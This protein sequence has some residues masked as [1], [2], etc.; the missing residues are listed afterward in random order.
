MFDKNDLAHEL[1]VTARQ[2]TKLKNAFENNMS[3]DI[4][5]S[6]NQISKIMRSEGFL[7]SLLSKLADPL[8]K[9]A[10]PFAKNI[11]APLGITAATSAIDAGIQKKIHGS[12]TATLIISDEEMNDIM[13]IVQALEDSTIL[14]K[15]VTKTIK[16]GTK[17]QKGRILSMLYATLGAS[18]SGNLLA[19][20]G[21]VRAGYG[22][23]IDF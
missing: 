9:V 19:G 22:N 14:L 15:G 12:G 4:K 11:L 2:R 10:V 1:L 7:G 17:E 8:L 18:L 13:K 21:I 23:E 3:T 16:N 6:K 20:K 5:L